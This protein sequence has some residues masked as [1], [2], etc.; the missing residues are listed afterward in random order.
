MTLWNEMT[1]LPLNAT[2]CGNQS[3]AYQKRKHKVKYGKR[4][5]SKYLL[6]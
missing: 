1:K 6:Y 5:A 2:Y 4:Q 3:C